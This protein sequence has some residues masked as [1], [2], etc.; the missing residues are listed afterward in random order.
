[1]FSGLSM[2]V[3][4]NNIQRPLSIFPCL[5]THDPDEWQGFISEK[6]TFSKHAY[7][8]I[9]NFYA[10]FH[11]TMLGNT[12]I[13]SIGNNAAFRYRSIH[14]SD[15]VFCNILL[16]GYFKKITI[17]TESCYRPKDVSISFQKGKVCDIQATQ[18]IS[19]NVILSSRYL[20]NIIHSPNVHPQNDFFSESKFVNNSKYIGHVIQHIASSLDLFPHIVNH[21]TI[22]TQ[23]EQLL[24]L[25][26]IYSYPDL[27]RHFFSEKTSRSKKIVK[28]IEEYIEANADRPLRLEDLVSLTGLSIRTIQEAFKKY[29]G[30]SPSHF[31]R[32]QRL[33]M[34]HKILQESPPNAT[35]LSIALS[36]GF[37]THA[38]FSECYKKRF[39]ITPLESQKKSCL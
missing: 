23:Y 15:D 12:K 20:S 4:F 17:N 33:L 31:L 1:M 29:R 5:Q 18:P 16:N 35:I 2:S 39:G 19:I 36:C 11:A 14:E 37:A 10:F 30:Y 34:A 26:F 8:D 38:H 6:A 7:T 3:D 24:Y 9:Q 32:E 28:I 25:S 22:A 21:P 27:S 13:F